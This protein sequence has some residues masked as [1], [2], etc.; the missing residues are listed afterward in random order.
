[1]DKKDLIKHLRGLASG[2]VQPNDRGLGICEE[3]IKANADIR[4]FV[5]AVKFWPEF[6]GD[7]L[8]PI[9]SAEV[10][11]SSGDAFFFRFDLWS[12]DCPE[13]PARRRLC[14]WYADY[15]EAQ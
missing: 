2:E 7:I 1:M 9:P 10:G 3:I 11:M 8:F 6:S 13:A 4:G 14:A 5:Q 15:L 12:D